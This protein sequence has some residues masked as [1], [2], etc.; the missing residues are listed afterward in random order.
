MCDDRCQ[1]LLYSTADAVLYLQAGPEIGAVAT[2]T[3]LTSVTILYLLGLYLG[4]LRKQ[5]P[6]AQVHEILQAL[7]RIPDQ[8]QQILNRAASLDDIIA[9]LSKRMSRCSSMIFIGR[10]VGYPT[11]LEGALKLREAVMWISR[12]I[13]RS[14]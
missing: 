8:V 9:P 11:A 12:G 2:K 6:Q 5:I 10:G 3:F 14:R 1:P 13:W 7:E 4:E